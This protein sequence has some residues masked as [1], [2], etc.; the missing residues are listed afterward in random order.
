MAPYEDKDGGVVYE[1]LPAADVE[2]GAAGDARAGA[3]ASHHRRPLSLLP[4]IALIFFEVSGG[5][6]GTEDAVAAAGPLLVIAGFIVFPLVWSVPEALITAELATAFPEN[7]GYVAWVTAAFGPFWGFQEGWWSWLSGVTDN[8]IY[9]VMLADNLRLFFPALSSGWQRVVFV[10]C[11]SIALTYMNY[12]GLQ[13]VGGAAVTTT[14]F[15]T[16]PFLL[17]CAFALPRADPSNWLRVDLPAVQ[18]GTFLNIMFWNLNYWDSVSCLAGEVDKPARTFPRALLWAVLLVVLSYLLPTMAALGVMPETGEW[19][20]GFYGKVAQQV[21]GDWLAWW[22]VLAA[23]ASQVGQFQAEMASDAFQLQGMAERG[24]LP[25]A[26]ARRSAHGTPT[27]GILLS[28]V[29][30]VCLSFFDFVSIVELLNAI[31]C[32]A[33]LLEF[34][35]FIA[36]RV[37]APNLP[38]PYRVPLPVWGLCLMLLPATGLLLAVLVLPVL[39]RDW[40]TVG[41]TA[42][43]LVSGFAL[44]PLLTWLKE[45]RLVDFG[46]LEFE[47]SHTLSGRRG[48]RG[49]RAAAAAARHEAGAPAGSPGGYAASEGPSEEG[50]ASAGGASSASGEVRGAE[51]AGGGTYTLVASGALHY[52]GDDVYES[53]VFVDVTNDGRHRVTIASEGS[54]GY[55]TPPQSRRASSSS[56]GGGGAFASVDDAVAAA[57][58]RHALPLRSDSAPAGGLGAPEGAVRAGGGEGGGADEAGPGAGGEQR[59]PLLPRGRRGRGGGAPTS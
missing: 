11:L 59:Q 35:A 23:A 3:S 58:P 53:D 45:S 36:L 29:G 57:R 15:I 22:V 30:V 2:E 47:F 55:A 42:S 26:L 33:E 10:V 54:V 40:L 52:P 18:W 39:A 12:R 44:Y 21:A 43:A 37:T 17:L 13:V 19:Q 7:S 1:R 46:D 41:A 25:K 6:F 50:S 49:R 24:F 34:A 32:L 31:Y 9:P 8:S 51:V 56:G 5:P 28:S 20:L 38:R 14:V 48:R 4:L 27:A 16:A